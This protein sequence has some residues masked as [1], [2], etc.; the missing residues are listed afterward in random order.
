MMMLTNRPPGKSPG[1]R[2]FVWN[3]CRNSVATLNFAWDAYHI[4]EGDS[5]SFRIRLVHAQVEQIA[6]WVASFMATDCT[7]YT[8]C[9]EVNAGRGNVCNFEFL[10][11][12]VVYHYCDDMLAVLT[13]L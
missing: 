11:G 9:D 1:Y 5:K 2:E 6:P 4:R 3:L 13:T 10:E 8:H 7:Q 12:S